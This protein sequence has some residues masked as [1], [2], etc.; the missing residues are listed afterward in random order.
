MWNYGFSKNSSQR[1]YV[2]LAVRSALYHLKEFLVFLLSRL[3]ARR[4]FL[5]CLSFSFVIISMYHRVSQCAPRCECECVCRCVCI[6]MEHDGIL[7]WVYFRVYADCCR[8][9]FASILFS[10]AAAAAAVIHFHACIMFRCDC[11]DSK[12][13]NAFFLSS[14]FCLLCI[15]CVVRLAYLCVYVYIAITIKLLGI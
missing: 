4:P 5:F 6:A 2:W 3:C 10:A 7:V 14:L 13:L 12:I 8:T 9:L 11:V 15:S 1:G